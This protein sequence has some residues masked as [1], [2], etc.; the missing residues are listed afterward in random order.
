MNSFPKIGSIAVTVYSLYLS[1]LLVDTC[2]KDFLIPAASFE[3]FFDIISMM[4]ISMALYGLRTCRRAFMIPYVFSI[5]FSMGLF[6]AVKIYMLNNVPCAVDYYGGFEEKVFWFESCFTSV[7]F[8]LYLVFA[9]NDKNGP[10][11]TCI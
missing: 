3:V 2:L 9:R 8:L 7:F 10:Y 11:F 4:M 6:A 1:Q 5:P